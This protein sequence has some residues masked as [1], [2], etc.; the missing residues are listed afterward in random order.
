[1]EIKHR[2]RRLPG[3]PGWL[4]PVCLVLLGIGICLSEAFSRNCV[5]AALVLTLVYGLAEG[6]PAL[7]RTAPCRWFLGW[8]ALLMA[9]L[10]CSAWY[11]GNFWEV[12]TSNEFWYHYSVAIVVSICV[13]VNDRRWISRIL[14]ACF[15]SLFL[16]D[17]FLCY[18]GYIGV[19]RPISS[20]RGAFML[21]AMF[22]VILLP[23]LLL[24]ALDGSRSGMKRA[25]Y[26]FLF[27]FSMGALLLTGTR[28]AWLAV[29]PVLGAILLFY[30]KFT[31]WKLV[32]LLL[33]AL[34][35]AGV[36]L[37]VPRVSQ[38]IGTIGDLSNQSQSERILMYRSGLRMIE[39][40]PLF[41]IGMGNYQKQYL[42]EYILPEAKERNHLH[43]HNTFLQFAIHAGI[44][45]MASYVLLFGYILRWAWRRRS[46]LFGL[47]LLSST[48]AL[49]LY[50]LT[51]YTF[52]GY[53][54]MRL[55]YLVL[56][57][58]IKGWDVSSDGGQPC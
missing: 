27:L 7:R 17:I 39:D 32:A 2:G 26:V 15:L 16:L 52:A 12:V 38:K 1:M 6:W 22:Y 46:S 48:C 13:F 30:G 53:A 40:H 18:Q 42:E 5:R 33:S 57:L 8:M 14:N 3:N 20:M 58:C 43:T 29:L 45:G 31:S 34:L 36:A 4:I 21:T 41:G 25:G 24:H 19:E 44:F 11:G 49:L 35:V 10:A 50:S 37:S 28:G 9:V 23:I 55:Y 47:M 54:G 56:G 51:D